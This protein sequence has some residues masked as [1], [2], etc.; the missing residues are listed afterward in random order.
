MTAVLP[1][2]VKKAWIE[3]IPLKRVGTVQDVANTV[4]YLS[5]D[6][7]SYVTG[8]VISVCGGMHT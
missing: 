3:D 5:S 6:L 7:S 4:L 8:Q 1:E 2:E